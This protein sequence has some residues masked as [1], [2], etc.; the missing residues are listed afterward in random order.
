MRG[1]QDRLPFA[2][3]RMMDGEL[4]LNALAGAA[5]IGAVAGLRSMTAPAL[6]S[7]A[8]RT[9]SIDLS[10]GPAAFLGTQRAADIATGL[11]L[12]ELVADKLPSTPDRIAPFPLAARAISGAVV[13]AAVCSARRKDPGPGALVGALAAIG[14]AFLGFALR[15]TLTRDAKVSGFLVAALEDAAAVGLAVAVLRCEADARPVAE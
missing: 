10:T 9:G 5:G 6:V 1:G 12:A 8:A 15:R 11:A 13:G 14:A 2:K 4:D 3:V 7:Q